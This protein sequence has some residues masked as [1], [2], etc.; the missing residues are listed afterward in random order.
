MATFLGTNA[1]V[2]MRFHCII[3]VKEQQ[4]LVH[5]PIFENLSYDRAGEQTH[6]LLPKANPLSN[7]P[8]D[9]IY[10]YIFF[11]FFFFFVMTAGN[12]AEK[13]SSFNS[14][15]KDCLLMFLL[16]KVRLPPELKASNDWIMWTCEYFTSDDLK[17]ILSQITQ[18]SITLSMGHFFNQKY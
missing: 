16:L 1:V 9:Y 15:N 5:V 7:E 6:N 13:Y 10:I 4:L 17:F 14:R 12:L 18:K 11:F 2:V 8:H 3:Q